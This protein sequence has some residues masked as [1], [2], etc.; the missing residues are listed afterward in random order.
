MA[1]NVNEVYTTVL[2]I[3]NKEQ[4]GYITPYEFNKLASQ[5]QLEVFDTYFENLTQQLRIGGNS[6]EYA[7]RVKLLQE[8]IANFETEQVLNVSANGNTILPSN[9]YRFGNL[10]YKNYNY[11]PVIIEEVTKKEFNLLTRSS[12]TK[13]TDKWPIFYREL[14]QATISPVMPSDSNNF[15]FID[16]VFVPDDPIWGFTEGSVGQ[17]LY[18]PT[19]SNNFDIDITDKTEV[20]LR[21]LAY[22]GVII[23]DPQIVQTAS[24]AVMQQDQLEAS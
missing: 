15:Y 12:L 7:D 22:A 6:S 21:I 14:I 2:S 17:Y 19:T 16:Y 13:P 3:L 1:I 18:D 5:V 24:Q 8:K 10:R 11:N 4:R 9:I 23:R 20:I